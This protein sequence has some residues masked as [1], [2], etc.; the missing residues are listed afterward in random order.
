M[1]PRE[2]VELAISML[3]EIGHDLE[4]GRESKQVIAKRAHRHAD[5]LR[6][7]LLDVRREEEAG[8]WVL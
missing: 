7:D 8:K 3:D 4:T 6:Q 5:R 1:S 2:M